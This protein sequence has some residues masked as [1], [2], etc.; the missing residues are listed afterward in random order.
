MEKGTRGEKGLG[1]D[2]NP[3]YR[4]TDRIQEQGAVNT[5]WRLFGWRIWANG[6]VSKDRDEGRDAEGREHT[7]SLQV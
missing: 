5:D 3:L 4:L 6:C 1:H 2:A 7:Q